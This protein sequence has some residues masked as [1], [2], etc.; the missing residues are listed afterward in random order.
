VANL[1]RGE[2]ALAVTGGVVLTLRFTTSALASLQGAL[3]F[4]LDAD[5]CAR[6]LQRLGEPADEDWPVLFFWAT[7]SRHRRSIDCPLTASH[8]YAAA[9]VETPLTLRRA[10]MDAIVV[11][12]PAPTATSSAPGEPF[13]WETFQRDAL[14]AGVALELFWRLTPREVV[15]CV[16]AAAWRR[17]EAM[18][19]SVEYARIAAIC[20][21]AKRI[22]KL[23]EL[24]HEPEPELSPAENLRRREERFRAVAKACGATLSTFDGDVLVDNGHAS[25]P[26][27]PTH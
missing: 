22:P 2:V 16:R 14:R 10:L 26:P 12:F 15:E 5:G 21:R 19:R 27:T 6:F 1:A 17:M 24:I 25:T 13:A 18:K 8:L 9:A 3:G 23:S 11:A 7:Q 20:T 4:A